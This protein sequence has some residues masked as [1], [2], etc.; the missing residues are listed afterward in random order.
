MKSILAAA[1]LL[2][3]IPCFSQKPQ[4]IKSEAWKTLYR[5]TPSKINDLVHTKLE[6]SFDLSKSWMYGKV[7]IT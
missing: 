2:I 4:D 1:I 5:G 6:V 7:W 3:S